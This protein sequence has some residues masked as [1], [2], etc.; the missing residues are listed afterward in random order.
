MVATAASAFAAPSYTWHGDKVDGGP[1]DFA[2]P[3][4]YDAKH[5]VSLVLDSHHV[6]WTLRG[7]RWTSHAT[8]TF[9]AATVSCS[10]PAVNVAVPV[11]TTKTSG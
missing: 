4:A 3:M 9:P 1:A 8:T 11:W 2:A 7:K 10:S 5:G 6:T